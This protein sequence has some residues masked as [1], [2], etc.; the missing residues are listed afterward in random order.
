LDDPLVR[1]LRERGFEIGIETNGT[2]LVPEGIDWVCV[3][4]KAVAPLVVE[5]GDEL[6]V[7]FPQEGAEPERYAHLDFTHFF[8][9]PMDGPDLERNTERAVRYC[10]EHPQWRLSLQVHKIVGI[11]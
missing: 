1:A 6:K 3:S 5:R 10:L 9:Q 8:I 4:P 2:R 7:I 11:P